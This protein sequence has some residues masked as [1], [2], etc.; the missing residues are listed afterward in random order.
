MKKFNLSKGF[1]LIELL[2]VIAIVGV[3]A[4]AVWVA[5]DPLDKINAANDSK[6]QSDIGSIATAVETYAA[7]HNGFYPASQ[8]DLTTAGDLKATLVKPNSSYAD[9]AVSAL[10]AACT[11]GT[12]CTS[13]RF[14]AQLRSKKYTNAPAA[15]GWVYGSANGKTCSMATIDCSVNC[16]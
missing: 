3:L 8:A 16:P 4:G 13:V 15:T 1:T 10:P 7:S 9:Y 11:G 12:T 2:V 6:V 14:C 5:I